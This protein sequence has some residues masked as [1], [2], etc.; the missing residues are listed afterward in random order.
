MAK[1]SF[2]LKMMVPEDDKKKT[3]TRYWVRKPTKGEKR[4]VK[5]RQ[6]N[7]I[8]FLELMFGLL[9]RKCLSIQ[10]SKNH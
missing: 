5:L 8:L 4:Q 2:E 1:K 6:E 10:N 9:K 3:G 7:M